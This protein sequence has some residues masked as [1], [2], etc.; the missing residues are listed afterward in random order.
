[1]QRVQQFF[2]VPESKD[3]CDETECQNCEYMRALLME[4]VEYHECFDEN[5]NLQYRASVSMVRLGN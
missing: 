4:C 3:D 2:N 1:M 5:K